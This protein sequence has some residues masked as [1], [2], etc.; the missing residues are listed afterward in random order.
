MTQLHTST[1]EIRLRSLEDAVLQWRA[2][3][4]DE[5][6][7]QQEFEPEELGALLDL[8]ASAGTKTARER[9]TIEECA[10]MFRDL[11]DDHLGASH[12][13]LCVALLTDL[14]T[15]VRERLTALQQE[16]HLSP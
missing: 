10:Q 2:G 12:G 4:M 9:R 3:D 1:F 14:N 7:L 8:A 6:E 5:M 13:A 16:G 15:K 11:L